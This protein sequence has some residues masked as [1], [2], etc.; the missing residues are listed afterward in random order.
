MGFRVVV[1]K[2]EEEGPSLSEATIMVR[3]KDQVEAY[4]SRWRWTGQR[5]GSC[6]P[7]S[8]GEILPRSERSQAPRLQGPNPFLKGWDGSPDKGPHR[9]R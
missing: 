6:A 2:K 9:I 7:E 5:P 3:V 1:E 4:G 8:V